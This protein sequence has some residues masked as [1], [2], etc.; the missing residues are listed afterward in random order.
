MVEPSLVLLYEIGLLIVVSSIAIEIFKRIRLPGLIGAILV[1]I[2]LGGP[3]G[4]GFVNDL[5]VINTLA[6]LG[7]VLILFTT[8]LEFDAESFWG[9][10]KRAF[11]LTTIGVISS[12][13]AGYALGLALGWGEKAAFLLGVVIAPSGTSVIAQVLN[14]QAKVQTKFGST[15]LTAC[16]VDDVEGVL[17]ISIALGAISK[18]SWQIGDMFWLSLE[19]TLFILLS[20][21]LGSKI[22]PKAIYRFGK[23]LSEEV[24]FSILLGFGL[25]LAFAATQ[26]GLAAITG[27]FIMGAIIPYKKIGE[28][29]GHRLYMMKEVFAT[30]FF[31]TIGLSINPYDVL[32]IFPVSLAI[33]VFAIGARLF[34]GVLGG[35]LGGLRQRI[36]LTSVIGLAIRAEM[37]F[38]IAREAVAKGIVSEQFLAVT[39]VI[40]IGSMLIILPLFSKL[41]TMTE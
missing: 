11:L 14:S 32:N 29:V 37:S 21:Y 31:T 10:G 41:S 20:I 4:L 27:A 38:I 19:S 23:T 22:L 34:G 33:L 25:I 5:N 2:F 24:L 18:E 36:L 35:L 28:K 39:T 17:L 9:S 16:V 6:I 15:L 13:I 3:G 12:I 26:V 30:I 40:V 8:G 1:G 7:S